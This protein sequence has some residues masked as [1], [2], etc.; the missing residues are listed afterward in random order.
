MTKICVPIKEKSSEKFLATFT[1]AQKSADII[2]V[3][4]DQLKNPTA[5]IKKLIKSKK[6]ILYKVTAKLANLDFEPFYI[7]FDLLAK[8]KYNKKSKLI[9]S[10]H[11]FDRTPSDKELNQIIKKMS[12]H[13]PYIYKIVTKAND[14]ADSLRI[15]K[16]LNSLHL[17]GKKAVCICMGSHGKI[18]RAAGHLF[19][20]YLMFAPIDQN[21][22]TAPG[23]ISLRELR[24]IHNIL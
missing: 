20:N 19:G 6:P 13:S 24:K 2:E 12:K 14:F 1:K 9:I 21:K 15:L 10:Y 8:P 17:Q 5:I 16:L 22:A 3:Y 4:L 11:N 18:T 23:Q 7:D